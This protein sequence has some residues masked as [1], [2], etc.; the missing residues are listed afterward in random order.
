[1]TEAEGRQRAQ[2]SRWQQMP[3]EDEAALQKHSTQRA[4]NDSLYFSNA[5]F[6]TQHF[7]DH[8]GV[9]SR[10]KE[11]KEKTQFETRQ[12]HGTLSH[13]SLATSMFVNAQ[14]CYFLPRKQM[15]NKT[16]D[17]D[18]GL[19]AVF[20]RIRRHW[21]KLAQPCLKANLNRENAK[22]RWHPKGTRHLYRLLIRGQQHM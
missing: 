13:D 17:D 1:M 15:R 9:S 7:G 20:V 16:T 12:Q 8:W 11:G 14:T 2:C 22:G 18:R 10:Q 5:D 21:R 6:F 4:C 19:F 3:P